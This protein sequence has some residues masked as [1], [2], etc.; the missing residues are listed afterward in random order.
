MPDLPSCFQCY[1]GTIFHHTHLPLQAWF[2]E[3]LLAE[4]GF[5]TPS[6][7]QTMDWVPL[8]IEARLDT[9]LKVM[10]PN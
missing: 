7:V 3:D 9:V 5:D 8:P 4:G 6:R 10:I 2:V 1:G